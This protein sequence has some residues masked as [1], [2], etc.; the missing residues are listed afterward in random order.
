M[1]DTKNNANTASK[2]FNEVR[3]CTCCNRKVRDGRAISL[4][5]TTEGEEIWHG[6]PFSP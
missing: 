3:R 6:F 4:C 2:T 1:N 5:I